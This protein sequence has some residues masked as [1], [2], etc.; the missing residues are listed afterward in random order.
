MNVN[1]SHNLL[2]IRL[3]RSHNLTMSKTNISIGSGVKPAH[4]LVKSLTETSNKVHKC[5]TYNEAI[6]NLIYENKECEAIDKKL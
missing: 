5:K 4:K 2:Q 1:E 6:D 3:D